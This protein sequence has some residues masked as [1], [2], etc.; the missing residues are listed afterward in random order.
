MAAPK[1]RQNYLSLSAS[2]S[3]A[4]HFPGCDALSVFAFLEGAVGDLAQLGAVVVQ[5]AD[6]AP[7]DLVGAGLEVV[8]AEG[9]GCSSGDPAGG[10]E[11]PMLAL[12]HVRL[13]AHRDQ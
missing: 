11:R 4:A 2:L 6:M 7:M 8:G 10:A 9:G 13:A 12:A 1:L 5:G 3:F